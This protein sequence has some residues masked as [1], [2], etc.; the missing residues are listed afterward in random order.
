MSGLRRRLGTAEG[1]P[2][3]LGVARKRI[4]SGRSPRSTPGAEE[5][6]DANSHGDAKLVNLKVE[7][8]FVV[9]SGNTPGE[10]DRSLTDGDVAVAAPET[11]LIGECIVDAR[12]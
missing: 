2:S 7:I 9:G 8:E 12:G 4:G 3:L 10:V 5:L 1:Y 11:D 6:E